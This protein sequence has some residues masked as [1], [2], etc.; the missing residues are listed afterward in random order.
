MEILSLP[1]YSRKLARDVR[2][3]RDSTS[4]RSVDREQDAG[5]ESRERNSLNCFDPYGRPDFSLDGATTEF[6]LQS[7][8]LVKTVRSVRRH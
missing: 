5:E 8:C 7:S 3:R 6:A 1:K 4:E 2:R